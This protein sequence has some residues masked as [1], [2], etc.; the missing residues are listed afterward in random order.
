MLFNDAG[1]L[2]GSNFA[3]LPGIPGETLSILFSDF[4][5]DGTPDLLVGNDFEQPDIF[6]TG[7]G[8]GKLEIVTRQDGVIPYTTTTTMAIKT[9]DLQN[10][11]VP[12]IYL[13]QIA[14]RSSGV[15]DTLKM[16]PL[17]QYCDQ[18]ERPADRAVCDFNMEIKGWYKSGNNFDPGYANRCQSLP[19]PYQSECKAMLIK[20]L[21]IQSRDPTLCELIPARQSRARSFCR[22]HFQPV[23]TTSAAER[24]ASIPQILRSN[25]LL[26]RSDG[27]AFSD[28]AEER[29]LDVGGWSWDTKI[30][31]FD[32][33]GFQDIYI[34]NGTWVP[35][36]VSPSNLFFRNTGQGNFIE[37]SG[38]FGLE[39]YLMTAAATA[40]DMDFDGDLDLITQPVNGPVTVFRNNTRTGQAIAF[41][42]DDKIGNRNG[43]GAKITVRLADGRTQSRELQLGG[44][45]MSF[46][47]PIAYFGLGVAESIDGVR[48]D[49]TDGGTTDIAGPLAAGA[50]F[51]IYRT[52]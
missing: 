3:D 23:R 20:D 16:Q 28:R 39:D 52:P 5:G 34:V 10:D 33:D 25:V 46:D 29:G 9:A 14:G 30:A 48:I 19:E 1:R 40:F 13:A 49:W 47:A 11:G 27:A 24:D 35:N 18:I 26:E 43:I 7:D 6:Y 31:D 37:A 38:P 17:G 44:G 8:S 32:N 2:D 12:E 21:A 36:E 50:L 45:F 15:S 42:I 51:T 22:I 41:A 4:N